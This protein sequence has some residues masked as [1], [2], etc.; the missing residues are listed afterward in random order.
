MHEIK[1]SKVVEHS[2]EALSI[3]YNNI[4]YEKQSKGEDVIVL[5]L[6]EPFFEIPLFSFESLPK[7]K[8]NHYSHSRGII[9]LRK[10]IADY[11]KNKTEVK[12]DYE[13]ELL[14]TAGSKIA[15][16][17]SLMSIL[18]PGDEVIVLEPAWVSY[19]EEIK[20]C[21]GVPIQIPYEKTIYDIENFITTKTKMIIINNPNNPT[22]R[23]YEKEELAHVYQLAKKYN[24]MIL[25]DEAY[26]DYVY[27]NEEFLSFVK[28]DPKNKYSIVINSL[29]KN[30]GI[31]GWRIG[32]LIT[33]SDLL[34]QILKIN[35]HLITCAPTILQYYTCQ[36]F[37]DIIKITRPQI[38]EILQKRKILSAYMDDMALK[39]L[40][41]QSTFYFFVSIENSHISSDEFCTKLLTG[42]NISI[43]PGLG[44]GKSCDKFVRV[45][46]GSEN[47]DRI[48]KGLNEIHDLI[49]ETSSK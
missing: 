3:K 40:T 29:S 13:K 9:E 16:H 5:S 27:T 7:R 41:G 24:I 46:I 47:L 36:Y 45:S 25:A 15:I 19:T 38:L 4:V 33:N 48:K 30:M 31:S 32:Y 35:Q 39:Y 34:N 26:S 1:P 21:Y 44:Y 17:M 42:K 18:N 12:I 37:S 8:I 23:I 28:L 49:I 10:K 20:L 6:G 22:G 11:Y 43:V 14:I 2:V